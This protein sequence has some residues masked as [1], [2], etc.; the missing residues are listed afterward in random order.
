M[1]VCLRLHSSIAVVNAA[2]KQV[3]TAIVQPGVML[4]AEPSDLE[5]VAI[6]IMVSIRLKTSAD[7]TPLLGQPAALK[8]ALDRQVRAVFFGV[9]APPVRLP[10][11]GLEIEFAHA[12]L[13]C[14]RQHR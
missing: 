1:L 12:H 4:P 7:L 11:V 13:Q 3:F 9:L 10:G 8:R 14:F 6:I 2:G 5:R